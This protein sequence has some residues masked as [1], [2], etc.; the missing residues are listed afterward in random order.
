MLDHGQQAQSGNLMASSLADI[1]IARYAGYE[2]KETR[3]GWFP[4][5]QYPA[6]DGGEH[7][8]AVAMQHE[9]GN[10]AERIPPRPF[11]RPAIAN[12]KQEWAKVVGGAVRQGLDANDTL[13]LVGLHMQGDIK[14]AI[15]DVTTP[16]LSQRTIKARQSRGNFD[17]K[18][19]NDTGHMIATLTSSV[20]EK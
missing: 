13:E 8:A 17:T 6:Q 19:L 14:E 3:A 18:P 7:V 10:P 15:G 20:A 11:M 16:S 9:F 1:L 4:S 2:K 5:A 12:K